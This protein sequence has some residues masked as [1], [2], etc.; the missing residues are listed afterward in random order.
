MG[1]SEFPDTLSPVILHFGGDIGDK[2]PC[3]EF[4]LIRC[5]CFFYFAF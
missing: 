2:S 5:R 4:S 3:G 1:L